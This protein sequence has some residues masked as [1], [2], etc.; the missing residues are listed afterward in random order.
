V[1]LDSNENI[2]QQL[3]ALQRGESVSILTQTHSGT[4]DNVGRD[5]IIKS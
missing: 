2:K 3:E 1:V 5:K 4:G